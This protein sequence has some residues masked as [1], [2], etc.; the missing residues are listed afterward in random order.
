MAVQS[1]RVTVEEFDQFI[2]QPENDGR[3]FEYIEGEIVEVVSNNYCSLLAIRIAGRILNYVESKNLGYI[4]GADGGYQI[5][6]HRYL[7]DVAFI[8]KKKQPEPSHETFNTNPPDL[9]VEVLSP[10]DKPGKVRTKIANYL[11]VGTAVWIVDPEEKEIEVYIPYKTAQA[12]RLG[13]VL[14]GGDVL[15]GFKLPLKDIFEP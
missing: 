10:T 3:R 1:H 15:P 12:L 6:N 14:D 7:P 5:G 9:A 13:D 4:T 8:S 11:A 2:S